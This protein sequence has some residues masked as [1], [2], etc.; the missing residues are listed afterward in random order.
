MR[1]LPFQCCMHSVFAPH[2]CLLLLHLTHAT[3]FHMFAARPLA[4]RA[5]L[6]SLAAMPALSKARKASVAGPI[7]LFSASASQSYDHSRVEKK[8]QE[9]WD[10]HDTF[11]TRRRPNHPKKYVLDMFPYPSGAGLHVGHP[12]VCDAAKCFD[13]FP[14]NNV[15]WF[16]HVSVCISCS[17]VTPPRISCVDTGE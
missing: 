13:G 12:E 8:W 2:F 3:A 15:L 14:R 9:Y 11:A 4:A 1:A 17:R 16:L 6:R 7:R 10:K 5:Q